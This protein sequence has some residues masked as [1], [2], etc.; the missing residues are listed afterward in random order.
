MNKRFRVSGIFNL[1]IE[2]KDTREAKTKARRI[3]RDSG[4][5]GYVI[6]AE[7]RTSNADNRGDTL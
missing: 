1:E 2:A 7:K 6:D 4:I 5:D 3:L